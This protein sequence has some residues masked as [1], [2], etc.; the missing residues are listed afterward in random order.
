MSEEKH[1]AWLEIDKTILTN[2]YQNL[3]EYLPEK[4]GMIAIVKC[5]GYG[6]D[7]VQEAW[8]LSDLGVECF[9]VA[10]GYEAIGL[11]RGGIRGDILVL[12]HTL[13]YQ[14][15]RLIADDLIQTVGDVEYAKELIK[16]ADQVG[17]P[18]RIQ[19]K[20]DTGMHRL[21]ISDNYDLAELKK[22]IC[23]PEL[24]L[25]GCF[26][27]FAV[28]DS[29]KPEDIEFT[30]Q[31]KARF[32]QWLLKAKEQGIDPGITHISASAAIVNYP[33]F[34][35]D[36]DYCRP[37]ILFWGYDSGEMKHPYIREEAFSL[38]SQIEKI[39]ILPQDQTIGYGRTYKAG[40]D[41]KVATI[42][43]GYGDGVPRNYLTGE[44][45]IEGVRCPIIGRISMDQL[46]VDVS[47][48]DKVDLFDQVVLIGKQGDQKI[49]V[50]E[51]ADKCGTIP[52]EITTG[53]NQRL[54]RV[55]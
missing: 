27:H 28:A 13:P 7:G 52:N 3:R 14:F 6:L 22:V 19:L 23:C 46:C 44:V 36:Y 43:I 29:N 55:Y 33:E 21:G 18:I 26:S 42:P 4:T 10:C 54:L 1:R 47:K 15:D 20:I 45:L 5:D 25:T 38:L 48:L 41:L 40:S 30:K 32:D 2:N 51:M 8:T 49:T 16:Y 31:Q 35:A 50:R 12:S 34:L 37:G 53:F 17:Q 24:E 9:G 39:D 11:R